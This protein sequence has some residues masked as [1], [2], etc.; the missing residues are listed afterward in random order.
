MKCGSN[1]T[2][3]RVPRPPPERSFLWSE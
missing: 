2:A 3:T 1:Y